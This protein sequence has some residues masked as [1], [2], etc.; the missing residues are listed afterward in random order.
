MKKVLF[1]LMMMFVAAVGTNAVMAQEVAK[2]G[3]KIE[4]SKEVHV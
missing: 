4:F 1:S 3:A 2:D